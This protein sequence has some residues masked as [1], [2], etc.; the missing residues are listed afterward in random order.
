MT[1]G[2]MCSSVVLSRPDRGRHT[3]KEARPDM[4]RIT[5]TAAVQTAYAVTADALTKWG[6]AYAATVADIDHGATARDIADAWRKAG[7]KPAN[8]DAVGDMAR[9]ATL[10]AYPEVWAVIADAYD[11]AVKYPHAIVAR[12]REQRGARYVD[13]VLSAMTGAIDAADDD[14]REEET[15]KAIR[16]AVKTLKAAKREA[17]PTTGEETASEETTG[18]ET[19][20]TVETVEVPEDE[21][22][23]AEMLAAAGRI[24]AGA[25]KR[26]SAGE[27][28]TRLERDAF[29]AQAA[30][31]A[32]LLKSDT[33]V[34]V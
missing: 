11:G 1:T 28:V 19:V 4:T 34:A 20:E 22:T 25:E 27:T 29:M 12:A 30:R 10:T 16:K 32:G 6:E 23:L 3:H 24:L 31:V 18:E 8:K 9:A 13:A 7:V 26:L 5:S 2:A 15:A 33:A 14:T 17:A 21:T